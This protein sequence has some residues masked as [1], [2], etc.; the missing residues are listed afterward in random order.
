MTTQNPQQS[1]FVTVVAWLFIIM[2]G[3]A[4][5]IA[6]LQNIMLHFLFPMEKMHQAML[7]QQEAGQLPP[8]AQFMV[9]HFEIFFGLILLLAVLTLTASIGLLL[10]KNWAR[11]AFIAL[12]I[13]GIIW[14]LGSLAAQQLFFHSIPLPE[15]TP[16]DFVEQTQG[17]MNVMNVF[18]ILVAVI[19]C[20]LFGWIAWR[21]ASPAIRQ[22]FR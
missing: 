17:M 11:I 10:R 18:S 6:L 8:L 21:L 4:T 19:V 1:A 15:E 13:A 22:E 12:M 16:A 2:S 20:I 9:G 5:F 14:N 7:Q 3:F